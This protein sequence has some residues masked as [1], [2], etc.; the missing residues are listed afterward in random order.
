VRP[1][2][3]YSQLAALAQGGRRY[4]LATVVE[5]AGSSPQKPGAKLALLDDGTL[6]GTVGGGAIEL[7]IV[8]AAR[9]LLAANDPGATR[10]IETHLTRDLGMCCGGRMS[11]FLER[12]DPAAMLWLFGAG[13]VNRAICAAASAVGF[14]VSVLDDR[15]E[16]LTPER[17][18][19]AERLLQ[20]PA[21]GAR[22][23][24]IGAGDLC[25]VATHD[26]ALDEQV[27]LALAPRPMAF[28]GCIGSARKA[29]RLRERLRQRGL[30]EAVLA[31]IQIPM[32]LEIGA[33]SPEEIAV[34]V[35]AELV[36]VR[37]SSRMRAVGPRAVASTDS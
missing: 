28:L 19:D 1:E 29:I 36:R 23:A 24:S 35:V 22:Q 32:G 11:V 33:Q 8:E 13:H 9:A 12:H 15:E 3:L 17:F 2:A 31:R 26:H 30:E 10:L 7:Q 16:W 27:L 18:A 37:A 5:T 4:V 6:L 25:A 34:A 20:D 14:R 21:F